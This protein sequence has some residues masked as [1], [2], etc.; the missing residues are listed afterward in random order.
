MRWIAFGPHGM[1]ALAFLLAGCNAADLKTPISSFAVATKSAQDSLGQEQAALD[2]AILDKS[3]A[4]AQEADA[5]TVTHNVGDCTQ[6]APRCRLFL[7]YENHEWP[8]TKGKIDHGVLDLMAGISTYADNLASIAN[9]DSA[10]K[11]QT[12]LDE[13]K[14]SVISIAGTIDKLNGATASAPQSV[15][16]KANAYAAPVTGLIAFGLQRYTEWVKIR[17]LRD[18]T[19]AMEV[20]FD[21]LTAKFERLSKDASSIR[22]AIL[23]IKFSNAY[24]AYIDT[25][26]DKAKVTALRAAGDEYDAAL[27]ST[28]AALFANLRKAH[29][30]LADALNHRNLSFAQLW[31]YLQ[32]VFD[33]ATKFANLLKQL[34]DAGDKV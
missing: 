23:D 13:T 4:V 29:G 10:A 22:L 8:F 6:T 11:I 20:I 26:T 25:P 3:L 15:S 21:D 9:S 31:P 34:E 24:E 5:P 1:A 7:K 14:A 16:A 27:Q 28:P 32:S 30:A 12:A 17:A 18:G 2:S 19:N 33:Q